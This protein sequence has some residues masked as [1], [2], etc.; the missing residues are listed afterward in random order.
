MTIKAMLESKFWKILCSLKLAIVLASMTTIVVIGGSLYMP[1]NPKVFGSM[2]NLTLAR[3]LAEFGAQSPVLT[4]WVPVA[5]V[6]IGALGVNTLCCFIDWLVHIKSR[7]RK[8][9]EYLIHLGVVLVLT[10]Y[11]WGSVAGFRTEGNRVFVGQTIPVPF[12][13]KS[14]TLESFEPVFNESGRPVDMI[15]GLSLYDG[16]QLLE[17]K[18]TR[19]NHP[20]TWSGLVILPGTYGQEWRGGQYRIFSMFTINYDPGA[21]AALAGAVVMGCGV[22]LT[23]FSFY[24][25]RSSGDHPN[26][27]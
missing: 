16:A 20:L 17:K 26:I 13:D 5:A 1:F 10:A 23:L 4:W 12:S 9:G 7:W 8:L 19:I 6:L 27:A 11:L 14:I 21:G 15:S 22:L 24:R 3:W 25:K 18:K 2:D